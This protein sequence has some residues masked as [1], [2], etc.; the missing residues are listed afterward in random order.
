[1]NSAVEYARERLFSLK[2]EKYAL[3]HSRLMPTVDRDRVIGVRI[4]VLRALAREIEKNGL[5]GEFMAELPHKYY[6][7][8]NLHAF[9]IERISDFSDCITECDRFLPYIDN[10][11]TCDSMR[12]KCFKAHKAELLPRLDKWISSGECYTVRYGIECLM[13]HYLDGDFKSEYLQRVADIRSEEY[14]V[15]MAVAWFF[16][17]ALT[18]RYA[19]ALPYIEIRR[20]DPEIHAMTVRK[21]L[22]S[23]CIDREKKEYLR[24]LG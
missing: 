3:F 13:L 20:L 12:P 8:N 16:A 7:E 18:K 1:M 11:A 24:S 9:L 22:D 5:A 15:K 10:W 19:D 17:T 23:L 6:E 14:Y 21:A 2:D 4:P